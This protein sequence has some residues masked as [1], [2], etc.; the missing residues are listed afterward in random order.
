M[1]GHEP[2]QEYLDLIEALS[3]TPRGPVPAIGGPYSNQE[4][5]LDLASGKGV[6]ASGLAK[7]NTDVLATDINKNELNHI[8]EYYENLRIKTMKVSGVELDEFEDSSISAVTIAQAIY[9]VED[10]ELWLENIV[11]IMAPRGRL[12]HRWSLGKSGDFAYDMLNETLELTKNMNGGP[13]EYYRGTI[14]KC[15]VDNAL[16]GLGMERIG[17]VK[18][19]SSQ[20]WT[21]QEFIDRM[22]EGTGVT[23]LI[24]L[25]VE[26]KETVARALRVWALERT[27]SLEDTIRHYEDNSWDIWQKPQ[28]GPY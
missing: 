11:R 12:G 1:N 21:V 19:K 7:T 8:D 25:D 24:D 17:R 14:S 9:L 3:V 13:K 18:A 16:S 15:E 27:D 10:W 2:T 6:I 5:V 20:E 4:Q 23:W 28:S 26:A 22:V